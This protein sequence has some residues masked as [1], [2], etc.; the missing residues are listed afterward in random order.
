MESFDQVELMV[1]ND[2]LDGL[3]SFLSNIDLSI[4]TYYYLIKLA[5]HYGSREVIRI[6]AQNKY[7]KKN[8][9]PQ[10]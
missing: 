8:P 9:K 4:S 10:I 1:K 2:D 3:N 5:E 6:L 7:V